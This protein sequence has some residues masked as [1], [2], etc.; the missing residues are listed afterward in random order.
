MDIVSPC[1]TFKDDLNDPAVTEKNRKF[2]LHETGGMFEILDNLTERVQGRLVTRAA[3]TLDFLSK[4]QLGV[5]TALKSAYDPPGELRTTGPRFDN[6]RVSIKDIT[7]LPSHAELLSAFAPFL[8]A[9]IPSSPHHLIAGT[10]ERQLDIIF[11]LLREDTFGPVRSAVKSLLY[12]LGTGA[13]S[14]KQDIMN[15]LHK[16]GGRWRSQDNS[17]S[18]DLNLY[19]AVN[20][21]NLSILNHALVVTLS[22]LVPKNFNKNPAAKSQKLQKGS[23]VG[24]LLHKVDARVSEESKVF[25]GSVEADVEAGR[26]NFTQVKITLHDPEVYT[27]AIQHLEQRRSSDKEISKMIFFEVPNLIL[28]TVQPFLSRLQVVE[29][30]SIP[31][32]KYIAASTD[33][34]FTCPAIEPALYARN[35]HFT[36][37]LSGLLPGE[38]ELKLDANNVDSIDYAKDALKRNSG[39]DASQVDALVESLS[40]ELAMIEG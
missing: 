33:A 11:R 1:P 5:L 36:F 14:R 40:R 30:S 39:L 13:G 19:G 20:F 27:N 18:V 22:F 12:D 35:P 17:N 9:N 7:I 2:V 28:P 38:E 23:V 8:P 31:F 26:G 3:P 29:P 15:F 34:N 6:D 37:D 16:G 4:P 32:A 25:L 24:L 21:Q 10:M